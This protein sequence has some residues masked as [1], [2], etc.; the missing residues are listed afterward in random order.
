MVDLKI[1]SSN[2]KQEAL[3]KAWHDPDFIREI[4]PIQE[5]RRTLL[6]ELKIEEDAIVEKY[7]NKYYEELVIER[8]IML[9]Y[10]QEKIDE[11]LKER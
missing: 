8:Q 7:R 5:K 6:E 11:A 1:L 9:N 10:V 4:R 3:T 2:L